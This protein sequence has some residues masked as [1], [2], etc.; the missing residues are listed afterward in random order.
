MWAHVS[1][2]DNQLEEGCI[3]PKGTYVFS[4]I[5]RAC[6]EGF[7]DPSK[8]DPDRFGPERQ[9]HV[10]YC[11]NYLVFGAGPHM[12]AGKEYALNHIIVFLSVL[13]TTATW[14]RRRTPRS[15]EIEYLP[16]A[17]PADLLITFD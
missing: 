4:S 15:D 1:A 17:Y 10:K 2:K 13:S 5:T 11:T 14:K 8:F 7:V 16:S 3:I 12:C 6:R 9:E